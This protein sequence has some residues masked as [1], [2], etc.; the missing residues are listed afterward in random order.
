MGIWSE[1]SSKWTPAVIVSCQSCSQQ[2][3]LSLCSETHSTHGKGMP[4]FLTSFCLSP[5]YHTI[6]CPAILEIEL[7]FSFSL[8]IW[9]IWCSVFLGVYSVTVPSKW[10][11]SDTLFSSPFPFLSFLLY[12]SLSLLC[13]FQKEENCYWK[14]HAYEANY[15]TRSIFKSLQFSTLAGTYNSSRSKSNDSLPMDNQYWSSILRTW[16]IFLCFLFN[17]SAGC[18]HLIIRYYKLIWNQIR[19]KVKINGFKTLMI[20][21]HNIS[22]IAQLTYLFIISYH[23]KT[24]C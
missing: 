7:T 15:T 3:Q 21:A 13:C 4:V 20:K 14:I 16:I 9:S 22:Q 1:F 19:D 10:S 6:H 24:T 2:C 8:A 23:Y 18:M 11:S 5:L 12:P 17:W